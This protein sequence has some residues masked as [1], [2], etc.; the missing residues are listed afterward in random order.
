MYPPTTTH[1]KT[2]AHIT[3]ITYST[4]LYPITMSASMLDY[5]L[6]GL[7]KAPRTYEQLKTEL[8]RMR[9]AHGKLFHVVF[10]QILGVTGCKPDQFAISELCDI[11][12]D[13][14]TSYKENK[15]TV[16]KEERKQRK[17]L[18][19]KTRKCVKA[20]TNSA[21]RVIQFCVKQAGKKNLAEMQQATS[22]PM[23]CGW[24][25]AYISRRCEKEQGL[26][27]KS[28]EKIEEMNKVPYGQI[29]EYHEFVIHDHIKSEVIGQWMN[30]HYIGRKNVR[31]VDIWNGE[32]KLDQVRD[33]LRRCL[34]PNI[35]ITLSSANPLCVFEKSLHKKRISE[36]EEE[37][38]ISYREAQIMS[39]AYRED[40]MRVKDASILYWWQEENFKMSWRCHP[41]DSDI[42]AA[43][44]GSLP[45]KFREM[46][47]SY[48]EH[49]QYLYDAAAED[50]E[51]YTDAGANLYNWERWTERLERDLEIL[52]EGLREVGDV[53]AFEDGYSQGWK[54]LK[55]CT[56][57][58][59]VGDCR[60]YVGYIGETEEY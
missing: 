52:L 27:K 35:T 24:N 18:W 21:A 37:V 29:R 41:F 59:Y 60:E 22:S 45:N 1:T 49:V 47:Q 17:E 56:R 6:S 13:L 23:F 58:I 12:D 40:R 33:E 10:G 26:F 15:T 30:K 5:T 20:V 34:A 42:V 55:K 31:H 8:D 38:I 14:K 11:V 36:I 54:V 50:E 7:L 48:K 46:W 19:K 53:H 4:T 9:K 28:F 16:S 25:M 57:D 51:G 2:Y 44:K 32:K 43:L 3:R 39:L